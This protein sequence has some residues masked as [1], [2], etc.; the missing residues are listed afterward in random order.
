MVALWMSLLPAWAGPF[1]AELTEHMEGHFASATDAAW[2]VALDNMDQVHRA[3]KELDHE[4]PAAM[5]RSWRPYNRAMR[6]AARD[7]ARASDVAEASKAVA[8]L[9]Q[10]CAACHRGVEEG[11]RLS[12]EETKMQVL[13][14]RGEHA[15]A[16]YWL[17]VG[18]VMSSDD[19]WANGAQAMVGSPAKAGTAPFAEA[20][21][22][23][24][25]RTHTVPEAERAGLW[26]EII[27]SCAACHEAAGVQPEG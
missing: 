25:A 19:A 9:G 7:V 2:Y 13:T 5:P 10:T 16:P 18:I 20:Y 23:L 17:W 3:A 15:L 11:P 12:P 14:P 21:D 6:V 1:G 26:A 22:Q 4:A 27:A 24:A 8:A